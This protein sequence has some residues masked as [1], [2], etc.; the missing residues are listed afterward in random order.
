MLHETRTAP[1]TFR[2]GI[3]LP[4]RIVHACINHRSGSHIV[5]PPAR[6]NV[7]EIVA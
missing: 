3:H 2:C 7:E 1:P 4:P 5:T 6:S